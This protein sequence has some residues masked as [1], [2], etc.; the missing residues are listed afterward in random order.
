MQLVPSLR[1]SAATEVKSLTRRISLTE[2]SSKPYRDILT[3]LALIIPTETALEL[4]E[5]VSFL[6]NIFLSRPIP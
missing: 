6:M 4:K 2:L 5:R 1:M 3:R